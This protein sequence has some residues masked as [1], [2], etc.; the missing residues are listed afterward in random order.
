MKALMLGLVVALAAAGCGGS[1]DDASSSLQAGIYTYELTE[2]YLVDNGI[3]AEQAANESG[4][5]QAILRDDGAFTDSWTTATG[6]TGSCSGTYEEGDDSRVTFK[7]STGCF[8]DWEMSYAVD[9]DVVTWS[10]QEALPPYD[11][12]E[13]QK[14]NEVFNSVPWTRVGDAS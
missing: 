5:H 7:W 14:V 1:S 13:D 11:S 3:S 12:A 10:D 8:G 6:S 2:Q 4:K 9:G